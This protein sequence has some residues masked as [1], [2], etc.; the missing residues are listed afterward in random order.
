MARV[1][2]RVKTVTRDS[3]KF[4]LLQVEGKNISSK[5]SNIYMTFFA[6]RYI[7]KMLH[8]TVEAMRKPL[9]KDSLFIRNR[10]NQ[11][12]NRPEHAFAARVPV[13]LKSKKP[14]IK[15]AEF[16]HQPDLLLGQGASASY[17]TPEFNII[18]NPAYK[19]F[20][21]SFTV[22]VD[23]NGRMHFGKSNVFIM[24]EFEESRKR[25]MKGIME[26]YLQNWLDIRPGKTLG[27]SHGSWISLNVKGRK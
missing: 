13:Q 1:W 18:I 5:R 11:I 21:Y 17:L 9:R 12:E 10:I 15:V 19:D 14:M 2:L 3:L 25:T 4:Q 20:N 27:I 8:T 16:Q 24:P 26:V 7:S 6:D 22:F 23:V